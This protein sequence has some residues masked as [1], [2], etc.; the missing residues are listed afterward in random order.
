MSLAGFLDGA[1]G[2]DWSGREVKILDAWP[3]LMGRLVK[4]KIGFLA[5]KYS[6]NVSM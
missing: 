4:R 1:L 3:V 2:G 6:A 5:G